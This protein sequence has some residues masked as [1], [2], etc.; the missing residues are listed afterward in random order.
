MVAHN[1]RALVISTLK[2]R[3]HVRG[4]GQ[5]TVA[6]S[7]S[8]H[9]VSQPLGAGMYQPPESSFTKQYVAETIR[10]PLTLGELYSDPKA[11][12]KRYTAAIAA[13]KSR[14]E[15]RISVESAQAFEQS[16]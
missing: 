8:W 9:T 5:A 4:M 3:K 2:Q 13:C 14:P 7:A 16:V 12:T 11:P 6:P 1:V 15:C 10:F